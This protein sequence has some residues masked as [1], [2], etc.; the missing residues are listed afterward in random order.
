MD[1]HDNDYA[2]KVM[3]VNGLLSIKTA[4][5]IVCPRPGEPLHPRSR[6]ARRS[7]PA[8]LHPLLSRSTSILRASR[9]TT[10]AKWSAWT[11][12]STSDG[13]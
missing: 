5:T 6:K 12:S 1:N 9:R 4:K 3:P 7:A 8:A 10:T 11:T 2:R 13:R